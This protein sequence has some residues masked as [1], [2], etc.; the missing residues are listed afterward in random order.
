MKMFHSIIAK[1]IYHKFKPIHIVLFGFKRAK[2]PCVYMSKVNGR[3]VN[4][5]NF[6]KFNHFFNRAYLSEFTH[7]FRAINKVV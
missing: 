4:L 2:F 6:A 3:R 1:T 5:V 7:G